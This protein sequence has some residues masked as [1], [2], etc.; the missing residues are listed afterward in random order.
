[1]K[2][3]LHIK[4]ISP[5][6]EEALE[7]LADKNYIEIILPKARKKAQS[8]KEIKAKE[9]KPREPLN[10]A[11]ESNEELLQRLKSGR[12][13]STSIVQA[14]KIIDTTRNNNDQS[15]NKD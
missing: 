4:L 12:F 9:E 13:G 6:A 11:K 10:F 15:Q 2:K 14:R 7:N 3:Q 8:L 5:L 1:M